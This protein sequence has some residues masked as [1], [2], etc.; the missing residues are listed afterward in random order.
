MS[1]SIELEVHYLLTVLCLS[2]RIVFCQK[3]GLVCSREAI[4]KRVHLAEKVSG[5]VR[6]GV[7]VAK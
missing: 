7:K 3:L 6:I 2:E 5:F 4:L 1:Q